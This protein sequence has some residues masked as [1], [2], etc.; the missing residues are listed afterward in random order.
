MNGNRDY[1]DFRRWSNIASYL[2]GIGVETLFTLALAGIAMLIL[3][4]LRIL[5]G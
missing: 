1:L 2:A 4:G 3:A 5:A